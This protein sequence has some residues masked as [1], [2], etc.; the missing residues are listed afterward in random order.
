MYLVCMRAAL[1]DAGSPK[2]YTGES[3][4]FLAGRPREVENVIAASLARDGIS[5]CS[6]LNA[7][8][9]ESSRRPNRPMSPK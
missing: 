5:A 3:V 1:I 9:I 2:C 7:S 8:I 6:P 4:E